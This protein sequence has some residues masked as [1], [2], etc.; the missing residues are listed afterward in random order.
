MAKVKLGFDRQNVLFQ[1]ERAR[2]IVK[3]MTGNPDYPTSNPPLDDV[4]LVADALETAYQESRGRDKEKIAL[5]RLRRKELLY[6]IVQLG[7][8][9]QQASAGDEEKIISS[10]F[11]VVKNA[12]PFPGT[13]GKVNNLRLTDGKISGKILAKWNKASDAVLYIIEFSDNKD[14]TNSIIKGYTTKIK[15]EIGVFTPGT[16]VWIRVYAVGRENAGTP[17]NIVSLLVR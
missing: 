8:F 15:K 2:F 10:G 17:S 9:V 6:L 11:D 14:F 13:A 3:S 4:S 16:K 5:M 1:L 12:T 7:A